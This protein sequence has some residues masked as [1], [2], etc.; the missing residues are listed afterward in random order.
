MLLLLLVELYGDALPLRSRSIML[1]TTT[2]QAK[3]LQATSFSDLAMH[4]LCLSF[5]G[6]EAVRGGQVQPTFRLASR[7]R[8]RGGLLMG[9]CGRFG[10]SRLSRDVRLA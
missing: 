5:R 9:A 6:Q 8:I 7:L 1:F 2:D 10:I 4:S 3:T